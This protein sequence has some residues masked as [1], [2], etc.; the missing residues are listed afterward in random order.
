MKGMKVTV[1]LA[2]MA[3]L[4]RKFKELAK[5][6]RG[7]ILAKAVE[8]ASRIM[9]AKAKELAPVRTTE[10]ARK[11]KPGNLRRA[12]R[13]ATPEIKPYSA[14]GGVEVGPGAFYWKFVE[15]GTKSRSAKPFLR[16]AVELTKREAGQKAREVIRAEILKAAAK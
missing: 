16:P 2:G 3:E 11:P 15:R 12:I 10:L 13:S 14:T 5:A 7:E 8:E 4:E 9:V 1:S 6:A